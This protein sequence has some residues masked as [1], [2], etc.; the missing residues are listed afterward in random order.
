MKINGNTKII[1][2]LQFF[3]LLRKGKDTSVKS[4][5]VPCPVASRFL[6]H[7]YYPI[8]NYT[9]FY[10]LKFQVLLNCMIVS[11]ECL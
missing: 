2:Q 3:W 6:L 4:S 9:F 7:E 5:P 1:F 8:H 10:S 11:E